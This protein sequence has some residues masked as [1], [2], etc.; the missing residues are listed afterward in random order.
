MK[1][2]YFTKGLNILFSKF[3]L[4]TGL[5][6]T[7]RI[8]SP[9]SFIKL[10]NQKR[11]FIK[12]VGQNKKNIF[13]IK[14]LN[15]Q[16]NDLNDSA[17]SLSHHYFWQD[18]YVAH[19]VFKNNPEKH[20]DIGSSIQ[21]FVAHVA[22]YRKIHVFDI[23][24]L[25]INNKNIEFIQMDIMDSK[26]T[27]QFSNLESLSCL[28]TLEHFGLGRYGDPINYYGHEIGLKNMTNMLKS[29]GQFYLSVPIGNQ[30]IEFHAHRIFSIQYLIDI[31]SPDFEIQKFS[32]IND[33]N[34][35]FENVDY[36]EGLINNFKC[37]FGCGIFELIKK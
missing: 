33:K 31:L 13:P 2:Y 16:Y 10:L 27:E 11:K 15:A 14:N 22:S 35:F 5:G 1:L 18:L 6:F 26:K 37:R 24:P 7:V 17:G 19:Q 4:L 12:Q 21:S 34:K 9:F 23:R 25:D 8:S 32:Y 3:E 36:H 20:Y 28:H 30:C 29:G